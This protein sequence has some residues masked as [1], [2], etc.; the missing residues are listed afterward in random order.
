MD[1][2]PQPCLELVEPVLLGDEKLVDAGQRDVQLAQL[3]V[4][5]EKVVEIGVEVHLQVPRHVGLENRL[6]DHVLDLAN[7]RIFPPLLHVDLVAHQHHARVVVLLHQLP[8][9]GHLLQ[10]LLLL[11]VVDEVL[12]VV[13]EGADPV[14]AARGVGIVA[15]HG[16]AC[17]LALEEL[18]DPVHLDAE[19]VDHA[20]VFVHHAPD[21]QDTGEPLEAGQ[22]LEGV[23]RVPDSI[24]GGLQLGSQLLGQNLDTG[25]N[26]CTQ[27]MYYDFLLKVNKSNSNYVITDG[28][29]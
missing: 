8:I 25:L 13:E 16:R 26:I 2:D 1:G 28:R 15:R 27:K 14:D 7:A 9:L 4:L 5:L 10:V 21:G 12:E 24:V 23:G 20:L 11:E 22:I 19:G 3:L 17:L 6:G 18:G 29:W